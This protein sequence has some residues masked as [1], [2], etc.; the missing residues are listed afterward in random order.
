MENRRYKKPLFFLVFSLFVFQQSIAQ[1]AVMLLTSGWKF[2]KAESTDKWL[3]ASIPGNIYTDLFANKLIPDPFLGCNSGNLKW[4]DDCDWEYKTQFTINSDVFLRS[5][6]ELEFKGLDTYAKVYLNDS[7]VLTADN[8]FRAWKVDCSR[9]VRMGGNSLRVVFKS[10]QSYVNEMASKLPF[11][12][13]GGDWAYIRKPAYQFGWDWAPTFKS[14]GIWKKVVLRTKPDYYIENFNFKTA[15]I[16]A[17]SAIV[18]AEFEVISPRKQ[19]VSVEVIENNSRTSLMS[20]KAEVQ[21]GRTV[22]QTQ[23]KINNPKRWWPNGM[24]AQYLYSLSCRILNRDDKL[25]VFDRMVGLRTLEVITTPDKSGETFYFK[26]NGTPL[27]AKGSNVVPPNSFIS[28]VRDNEW[29]SLVDDAKLSNMNM[30]RVWGGGIYPPDAFYEACSKKGI[31][32]WQDFMFA[33]SMYPWNSLFIKNVNGEI[34]EQI[35][36]LRGFPCIA[37]YCGNNEVDEGW[38]NWGWTKSLDTIPNAASSAWNGYK[39]L[40]HSIIPSIIKKYDSERFYWPSS[41]L[42]GW[43]KKES[44]TNGDSHYWGVWWGFEPFEVYKTKI[45]RFMSEY[46]FQAF[47][48]ARTVLSISTRKDTMPNYK[49][50]LSHQKHPVGFE[51]IGKYTKSEGFSPKNLDDSIYLSQIVQSIGY[52]IAIESHRFAM[53][54]CMGTLYWQMN[55]CWPGITWSGIDFYKRWKAVQY[56]VRDAYKPILISTK[57]SEKEIAIN[58]VS[59]YLQ[60]SEGVLKVAIYSL[61]GDVLKNWE[62][63]VTIKPNMSEQLLILPYAFTDADS[64]STFVYAEFTTALG[65][66]FS[67]FTYRCKQGNLKLQTP[68]IKAKVEKSEAGNTIVLKSLKPAFYVQISSAIP[69]FKVDNNYF[70]MLPGKEYR[71]NI[72]VGDVDKIDSKS[73]FDFLH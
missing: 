30:L 9:L 35:L 26:V 29:I 12:L 60:P 72:L 33:C 63:K 65:E 6:T 66:Q 5:D 62:N 19:Q 11:K 43:G 36:R 48:D 23:F 49:E 71:V 24:G 4:V 59:D 68:N 13:P 47:P 52:R 34:T 7:L 41:P 46:G 21:K 32:V 3:P 16:S 45:P 40:F 58:A 57:I 17:T 1:E 15:E 44:M 25:V 39:T 70:N 38:H 67:S 37:L 2:R 10:A 69:E 51:T 28:S 18:I 50:L 31:L 14:C 27:F 53:P 54:Y 8:M 61:N 22:I 64:T 55:D 20:E 42:N 73:L 56:T